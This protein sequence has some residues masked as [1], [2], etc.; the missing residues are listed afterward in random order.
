M[1]N[2]STGDDDMPQD[3]DLFDATYDSQDD[4]CSSQN[5]MCLGTDMFTP[6]QME[7]PQFLEPCFL[8]KQRGTLSDFLSVLGIKSEE[9]VT[10]V[11]R[12][13]DE[14]YPTLLHETDALFQALE[15]EYCQLCLGGAA[16]VGQ[17]TEEGFMECEE[18]LTRRMECMK[19]LYSIRI[20]RLELR[21]LME[22]SGVSDGS[23]S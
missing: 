15:Q 16:K 10:K 4:Y 18:N 8:A 21:V 7:L 5:E 2:R 22:K 9:G 14:H 6:E 3:D 13:L 11:L 1:S 23:D 19:M 12:I 17:L 20:K